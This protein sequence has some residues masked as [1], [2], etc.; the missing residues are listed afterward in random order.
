M[1]ICRSYKVC[2]HLNKDLKYGIV[3][4]S[5]YKLD[6]T[7]SLFFIKRAPGNITN[8]EFLKENFEALLKPHLHFVEVLSLMKPPKLKFYLPK[9][10]DPLSYNSPINVCK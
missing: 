7:F 5:I 2:G 6:N 8:I 1:Y 9:L 3:E 10:K 4:M